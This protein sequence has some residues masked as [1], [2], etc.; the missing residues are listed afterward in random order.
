MYNFG[1]SVAAR[2]DYVVY[3]LGDAAGVELP[4]LPALETCL[5]KRVVDAKEHLP[6]IILA[7]GFSV[8]VGVVSGIRLSFLTSMKI[9]WL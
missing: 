9:V 8:S 7:W 6:R 3:R 5:L 2:F 1:A 4:M